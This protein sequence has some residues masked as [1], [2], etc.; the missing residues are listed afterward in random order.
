MVLHSQA[1]WLKRRKV[2][3]VDK[4]DINVAQSV[5]GNCFGD[6]SPWGAK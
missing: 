2:H 4:V 6:K 3:F 1:L 5:C